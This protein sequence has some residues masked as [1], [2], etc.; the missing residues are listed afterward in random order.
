MVV[1]DA[2]GRVI[3]DALLWNDTRSAPGRP[4]PDRARSA[5]TRTPQRVGVVPVASFTATKLRWLR[6]AEPANAAR[7]AAVALPHDWLTWRLLGYGPARRERARPGPGCADHRPV[8]RERNGV[9]E[10][11]RRMRTT[12]TCSSGRSGGAR[13]RGRRRGRRGRAGADAGRAMPPSSCRACSARPRPPAARRPACWSGPAPGD[14]A[15]AALGLGAAD[16]DVVVSIGTS[17][18]VFAVTDA[19]VADPTGTVAGFADASGLSLPLIAT[20]NAA[21]VLDLD[22]RPARRRPRR[23]GRPRPGSAI[24]ARPASCSCPTSRASARRTCPTRQ[25]SIHGL[26]IAIDRRPATSRARRSRGCCADWPTGSTPCAAVGVRETRI[27]LIGGA[28]QNPAV[29]ARRRAGLRRARRR[30]GARRVRRRRRGRAGR[31]GAHRHAPAVASGCGPRPSARHPPGHPRAVRRGDPDRDRILSPRR[32]RALSPA[33]PSPRSFIQ[34]F[35]GSPL[36]FIQDFSMPIRDFLLSYGESTA[37]R[38]GSP[39]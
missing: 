7:V 14:N 19:P 21:R 11:G 39:E 36:S 23:A 6:D 30:A 34:D 2:E 27:L 26:T 32:A 8:G 5:R 33:A 3:R 31:L 15:G 20:L 1:L 10:R 35:P 18:T 24:P 38:T 22:R 17:G 29:A 9:L 4:R 37:C 28:A 16:G 13:A 12:S 25:A